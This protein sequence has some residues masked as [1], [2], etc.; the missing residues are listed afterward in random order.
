[1]IPTLHCS[2]L[3]TV[4]IGVCALNTHLGIA[5][6]AR[7]FG[8]EEK[9]VQNLPL[10]ERSCSNMDLCHTVGECLKHNMQPKEFKCILNLF[11]GLNLDSSLLQSSCHG[12]EH[13]RVS[14]PNPKSSSSQIPSSGCY[15]LNDLSYEEKIVYLVYFRHFL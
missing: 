12:A 9:K 15:C 11:K 4:W 10:S 14:G 8:D 13:C 1:M 5:Q 7:H 6:S 3:N 2:S